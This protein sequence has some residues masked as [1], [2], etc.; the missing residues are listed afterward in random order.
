M[1]QEE[2]GHWRSAFA[3]Y[4]RDM[5]LFAVLCTFPN[6]DTAQRVGRALVE[7]KL[8]ACVN[9]LPHVQSIYRW[10]GK[11]E[12]AEEVLAV[13]K[14]TEEAYERLE[15]RLKALHPYDVPEII[16][17]PVERGDAA[18]VNWVRQMTAE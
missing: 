6:Q 18:Y 15:T 8:A 13:V 4:A 3:I 10:E 2:F 9:V 12:S 1:S 7:E 5:P 11:V 14:T 17:I 16:A